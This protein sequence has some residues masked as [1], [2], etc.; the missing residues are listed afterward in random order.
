MTRAE[1]EPAIRRLT[2]EWAK[3]LAS[4]QRQHPS[5]S[6]FKSWLREN[7]HSHYL[8]FRSTAGAEH[9]A[10]AWFDDELKQNWRR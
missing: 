9:D 3:T 10:E 1:A 6:S 2:T 8:S 4:E 5:F 7:G